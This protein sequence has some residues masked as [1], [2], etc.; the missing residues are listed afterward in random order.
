[1]TLIDEVETFFGTK[2]LY[3][4]LKTSKD[5]DASDIKKAYRKVSLVCHPDRVSE[6]EKEEA[7]K[8]FQVLAQVHYV[9][10]DPERRKLYDDHGIIANEDGL[11]SE[12]DWVNYWRL[13]FPKITTND[14][15]KF[16]ESYIGS[17][18]EVDDLIGIYERCKGD[19]DKICQMHMSFDEERTT[20]QLKTLIEE[21]KIPEYEKFTNEPQSRKDKRL[22]RAKK[23]AAQAKKMKK[24][25]K[26]ENEA[27]NLDDLTAMI[28]SRRE[29]RF[30]G[31]IA[32]L[33]QK[34]SKAGR[35]TKRKRADR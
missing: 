32:Q 15:N 1:M 31:M 21:G 30:D 5:V 9:L 27:S 18:Q 2:N 35:G 28:R 6:D 17:Q 29:G 22:R 24:K 12:A 19:M 8:R 10:S 3:E 4:V 11:G 13:L 14:I 33:E 20:G 26:E 25:M 23:E 16:M 7:T 34:Y